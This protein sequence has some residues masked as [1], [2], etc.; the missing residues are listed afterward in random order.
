MNLPMIPGQNSN[1]KNGAKVVMVDVSSDFGID[2][3]KIE[4]GTYFIK[5]NTKK[6]IAATKFVKE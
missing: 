1:G 2:V 6:G 3:S 4:T 5:V